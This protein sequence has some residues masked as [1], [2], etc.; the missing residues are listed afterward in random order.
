LK[1]AEGR[2]IPQ[3]FDFAQVPGLSREIQQKLGAVRP[4]TLGQA[5]R[6]PGVTPAAVAV[7]DVY[8][9]LHRQRA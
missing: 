4:R 8:L 9:T 2:I 1:E 6:I 3:N 5:M 7:L